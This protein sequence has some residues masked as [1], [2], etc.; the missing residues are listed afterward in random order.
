MAYIL[1]G[2]IIIALVFIPGVW[3]NRVLEKYSLPADRYFGS[4][5]ELARFLLDANALQHVKI[6]E[7][8]DGDHYDPATKTVRLIKERFNSH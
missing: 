7:T 1:L 8:E 5:S 6:E 4:G 2:Y 3:V